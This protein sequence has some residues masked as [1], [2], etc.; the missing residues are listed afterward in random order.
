MAQ[1]AS[2]PNLKDFSLLGREDA[3]ELL[4]SKKRKKKQTR[5]QKME[6]IQIEGV[7]EEQMD[8][9]EIEESDEDEQLKW[10]SGEGEKD[11]NEEKEAMARFKTHLVNVMETHGFG[12]ERAS[13]M[14]WS[15]FLELLQVLNANQVYFR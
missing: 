13:K 5:Q 14:H 10:K 4:P 7:K 8:A 11:E 3:S 6:Q 1:Q 15:R 9:L 12:K 2:T